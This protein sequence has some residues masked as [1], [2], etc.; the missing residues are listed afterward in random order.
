M[1][2]SDWIALLGAEILI[3]LK[4]TENNR[5]TVVAW[6]ASFNQNA[7]M[8]QFTVKVTIRYLGNF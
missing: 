1:H 8:T 6:Q 3:Y 2:I 7:H 5:P 4:P